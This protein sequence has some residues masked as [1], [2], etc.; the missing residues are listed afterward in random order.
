M[1]TCYILVFVRKS[2]QQSVIS[3]QNLIGIFIIYSESWIPAPDSFYTINSC[4]MCLSVCILASL[5]VRNLSNYMEP[6]LNKKAIFIPNT[7]WCL[8][9]PDGICY[10]SQ[11][12]CLDPEIVIISLIEGPTI[13]LGFW[14]MVKNEKIPRI[15]GSKMNIIGCRQFYVR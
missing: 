8:T 9:A 4:V 13:N 7:K 1:L 11:R 10:Q 5:G 12:K 3:S 15:H 6:I 2:N 14:L